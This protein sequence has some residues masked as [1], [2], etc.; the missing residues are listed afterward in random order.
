M[1][2][3]QIRVAKMIKTFIIMIVFS[4]LGFTNL[5]HLTDLKHWSFHTQSA[6]LL[7]GLLISF[8]VVVGSKYINNKKPISFA[9]FVNSLLERTYTQYK[10]WFNVLWSRYELRYNAVCKSLAFSK[11]SDG[12]IREKKNGRKSSDY[13][14]H[15]NLS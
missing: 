2:V 14:E 10:Y 5:N 4:C 15:F 13:H 11:C 12:S 8:F 6:T 9:C 1:I 3:L 7:Y